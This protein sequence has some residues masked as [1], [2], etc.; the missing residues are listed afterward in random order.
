MKAMNWTAF[1]TVLALAAFFGLTLGWSPMWGS[2]T[3]A[4]A[5]TALIWLYVAIH[6]STIRKKA[7]KRLEP[8]FVISRNPKTGEQVPLPPEL[9]EL[10]IHVKYKDVAAT[11]VK[12]R[13]FLKEAGNSFYTDESLAPE[14]RLPIKAIILGDGKHVNENWGEFCDR[15]VKKMRKVRAEWHWF[16]R[17]TDGDYYMAFRHE[18]RNFE[19]NLPRTG[20]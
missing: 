6:N 15:A 2:I 8:I 10:A 17:K 7:A 13:A 11:V 20:N 1:N 19:W 5:V 4:S 16:L 3:W 14:E 9:E 18:Q 12:Q